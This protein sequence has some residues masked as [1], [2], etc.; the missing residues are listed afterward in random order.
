MKGS[1]PALIKPDMSKFD[2]C[3]IPLLSLDFLHAEQQDNLLPSMAGG[4]AVPTNMRQIMDVLSSF[5]NDARANPPSRR[6]SS[7]N[8]PCA[9]PFRRELEITKADIVRFECR[10][11][12]SASGG[13][14]SSSS[15]RSGR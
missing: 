1:I 5:F 2:R 9:R 13:S 7:W 8:A 3:A 12:S 11:S 10:E 14:F 15:P 6:H 4:M